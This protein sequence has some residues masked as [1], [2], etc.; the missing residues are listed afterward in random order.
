M[1]VR[2]CLSILVLVLVLLPLS[3]CTTLRVSTDYD[4]GADFSA[5]RDYAWLPAPKI[6]SGDPALSYNSLLAPRLQSAVDELLRARGRV[7]VRS[8]PDFWLAYRFTV[9][10]KESITYINHLYGYGD[11]WYFR[12]HGAVAGWYGHTDVL[13]SEYREGTLVLDVVRAADRQLVWRGIVVDVI[14]ED[15][16]PEMRE[17]RIREAVA[18]MLASFPPTTSAGRPSRPVPAGAAPRNG[19]SSIVR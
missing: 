17:R 19:G 9:R 13:V 1:S 8:K 16:T 4:P 2:P 10:E 18:K 14:Y 15:D 11:G 5:L 7:K 3:A 6:G 12:A